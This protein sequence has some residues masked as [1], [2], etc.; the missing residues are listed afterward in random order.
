MMKK[1]ILVVLAVFLMSGIASAATTLDM[2]GYMRIHPEMNNLS[3]SNGWNGTFTPVKNAGT[4]AFTDQRTRLYFNIKSNENVGAQVATEI[5]AQWGASQGQN[6]ISSTSATTGLTTVNIFGAPGNGGLQAD[7]PSFV[8]K[9]ANMWFKLGALKITAGMMSYLD[10]M[11]GLFSANGDMSG[12][13]AD[14]D[15][16][17]SASFQTGVFTWWDQNFRTTDSVV[18]IPLAVKQQLGNGTGT[19]FFYTIQDHSANSSPLTSATMAG[20]GTRPLTTTTTTGAGATLTT[21]VTAA[22]ESAQI[23]YAGLN[24]AGKAG[25]ISYSAFGVYNFGTFKNFDN[26]GYAAA[27]TQIIGDAAISA[28]AANLKVDVKIGAGKLR[29]NSM[30]VSG[31]ETNYATQVDKFRGFIPGDRYAGAVSNPLLQDDV[32]LLMQNTDGIGYAAFLLP[33]TANNGDGIQLAYLAYD[34]QV[35]PNIN[36]KAVVGYAAADKDNSQYNNNTAAGG[37]K[38]LGK[39]MGTEMNAQLRYNFDSNF[40][41][42]AIYSYA[43]LGDYFKTAATPSPDDIWRANLKFTYSF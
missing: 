7:T 2:S 21:T 33:D 32:V 31:T 14:Y 26:T 34:H 11:S 15:L 41:I 24:Y 42:K 19:L 23:Y 12:F 39:G 3:S 38:K 30:Y 22:Y 16:S 6:V 43:V 25:D 5:N 1:L 20:R 29:F 10:H 4:Q 37:Y 13:K 35:L 36:V 17:R 8:L 27:G 28:I 18:F 40:S 9:S